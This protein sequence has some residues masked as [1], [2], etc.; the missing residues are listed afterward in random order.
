MPDHKVY[1]EPFGGA[2]GVLLRKPR[3]KIE[4]YNDLDS[5]VVEFFTILRDPILFPELVRRVAL[6]PFSRE[7]FELA[8]LPTDD[9]IEAARRFVTRCYFGYGSSS[10]D[11]ADSNGFRGCDV[12]AGKSYAIE[13]SGIPTAIATAAERFRGVTVERLDFRQLIPKFDSPETLFYVDPPYPH[14]TRDQGGKGYVH[15]LSDEDHRQ[16]AW[17]LKQV[18]GRVMLSGYFCELYARQYADWRRVEK[19]TTAAGHRGAVHRTEC[20]WMNFAPSAS[21]SEQ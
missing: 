7:E 21:A 16:L 17:I 20:L 15:E 6:T 1:V 13:W 8:Y 9:P 3:S 14:N 18:K 2:A 19:N 11:P 4:V 12:R 10:V 5:Q